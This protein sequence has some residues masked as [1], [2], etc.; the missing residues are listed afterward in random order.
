[1]TLLQID[2]SI[3]VLAANLLNMIDLGIGLGRIYH[4]ASLGLIVEKQHVVK[5]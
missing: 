4:Q 3:I 1:M 2:K 5:A